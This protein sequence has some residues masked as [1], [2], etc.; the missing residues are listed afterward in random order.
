[1]R[2]FLFLSCFM[3]MAAGAQAQDDDL[4]FTPS[5]KSLKS[6]VAKIEKSD[7]QPAYYC[8]SDRDVDEYNRRG[9]LRSYYQKIGTDTLGNDIIEFHAGDGSYPELA[10]TAL[11]YPGSAQYDDTD[12][13]SFACSRRMGR[14]DDFYGWWDPYYSHY[15]WSPY[16][17][18]YY[19]WY[20]PWY[21]GGWY[22]PWYYDSWYAWDWYYPYHYGWA[23]WW[24]APYY[25]GHGRGF[26]GTRNHSAGALNGG[27]TAAFGGRRTTSGDFARGGRDGSLGNR[28]STSRSS[29]SYNNN[30]QRRATFGRERGGSSMSNRSFTPSPSQSSFGGGSRSS[31]GGG[32]FGGGSRGGSMGGG[33]GRFGGR[34]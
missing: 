4:Y 23:G 18:S 25:G 16:W 14:F 20:S 33:G 11:V 28:R 8:G 10:D 2:R 13:E 31:F 12:E 19:G 5:K 7:E 15:W 27:R 3:L 29:E 32:S 21:Y 30:T 24:P 34:R 6:S 9:K 17:R 22:S 1:M 26:S